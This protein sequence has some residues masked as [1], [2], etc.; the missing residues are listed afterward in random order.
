MGNTLF[1]SPPKPPVTADSMI[2]FH[3]QPNAALSFEIIPKNSTKSGIFV[4][5]RA[6][7]IERPATFFKDS[8]YGI[9]SLYPTSVTSPAWD[10]LLHDFISGHPNLDTD[11]NIDSA[12]AEGF[13]KYTY[14]CL[15]YL[16]RTP[17]GKKIIDAL[18]RKGQTYI[19]PS[20]MGNQIT[21]ASDNDAFPP[22]ALKLINPN[23]YFIP[24]DNL[25]SLTHHLFKKSSPEDSLKALAK[26]INE[27]PLYSLFKKPPYQYK[28]GFIPQYLN[29][30]TG[31][32]RILHNDLSNWFTK[33]DRSGFAKRLDLKRNVKIEEASIADFIRLATTIHLSP[34]LP[35]GRGSSLVTVNFNTKYHQTYYPQS[36]PPAI[37]LGH[38]L[39]HAYW[40]IKGEQLG[41]EISH[42]STLLFELKCVG[43][44]PWRTAKI[45]EN[46]LR[47]DWNK[48]SQNGFD[49][50]H[51]KKVTPRMVYDPL[52]PDTKTELLEARK[53]SSTF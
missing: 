43:L 42:P 46:A 28:N 49:K 34:A 16:Y 38:E 51:K 12:L 29:Q 2:G 52:S 23:S 4:T 11:A 26:K 35:P 30:I 18:N 25:I 41:K 7:E 33:G 39:I 50:Y 53:R 13:L 19:L 6:E 47:E 31:H 8:S 17:T 15:N 9:D 44:G 21:G 27:T 1:S 24:A 48:L 40:A 10:S 14:T 45:A 32:Q 5:M 20:G 22:L 37:G 3:Y 36:R